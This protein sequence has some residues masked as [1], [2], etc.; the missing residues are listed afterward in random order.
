MGSAE[1]SRR[2]ERVV[3]H[4]PLS[5]MNDGQRRE[6]QEALLDAGAFETCRGSGRRPS[7]GAEAIGREAAV[8]E[9]SRTEM[10]FCP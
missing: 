7:V 2:V 4:P 5:E 1:L 6:F 10:G 8:G 3:A 9:T